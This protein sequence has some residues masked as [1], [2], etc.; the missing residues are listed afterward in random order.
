MSTEAGMNKTKWNTSMYHWVYK[1]C[2]G[3][4]SVGCEVN[5]TK[6]E[7]KGKK[8]KPRGICENI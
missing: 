5:F 4:N 6:E 1:V 8:K 3:W 2:A 7:V